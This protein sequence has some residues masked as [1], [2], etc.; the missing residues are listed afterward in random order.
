MLDKRLLLS[1]QCNIFQSQ[2][3]TPVFSLQTRKQTYELTN[4]WE[5]AE[6]ISIV[7]IF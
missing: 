6:L 3:L 7:T 2:L 4:I 5:K 1:G